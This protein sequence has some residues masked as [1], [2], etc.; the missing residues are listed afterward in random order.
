VPADHPGEPIAF[1]IGLRAEKFVTKWSKLVEP[2]LFVALALVKNT[3]LDQPM[4][5]INSGI[6]DI[7]ENEL[8]AVLN[9]EI[10]GRRPDIIKL[11]RKWKEVRRNRE[12]HLNL[13]RSHFN[14]D[15]KTVEAEMRE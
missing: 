13:T 9:V 7:M 14:V 15:P 3:P 12:E 11:D 1:D 6:R 5:D 10:Q 8:S 4:K 2:P